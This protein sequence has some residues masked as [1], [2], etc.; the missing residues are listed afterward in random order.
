M[1]LRLV[2]A[3]HARDVAVTVSELTPTMASGGLELT[4]LTSDSRST[5]DGY[6]SGEESEEVCA[7]LETA[8]VRFSLSF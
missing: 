6:P 4:G 5:V 1:T 3:G 8:R 7:T 2:A